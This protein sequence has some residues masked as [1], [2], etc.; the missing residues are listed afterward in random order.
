MYDC[1]ISLILKTRGIPKLSNTFIFIE[2]LISKSVKANNDI[3]ILSAAI[4]RDFGS[5]IILILSV[6]SSRISPING[7]FPDVS[8]SA[9]FS[10]NF[11]FCT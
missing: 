7:N 3:I 4:V 1:N 9:I 10:I 6:V 2:N 11:D 5:I 8:N